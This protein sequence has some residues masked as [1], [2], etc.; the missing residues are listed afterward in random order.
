MLTFHN[1]V[2]GRATLFIFH[3]VLSKAEH[4]SNGGLCFILSEKLEVGEHFTLPL[5]KSFRKLGRRWVGGLLAFGLAQW[6]SD[7]FRAHEGEEQRREEGG[8][9]GSL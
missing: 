6:P 1:A 9:G 3:H 4:A 7:P 8:G 2:T 5:W